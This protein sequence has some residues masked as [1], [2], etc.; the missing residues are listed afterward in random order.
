MSKEL[1]GHRG[2]EIVD[3]DFIISKLRSAE[4]SRFAMPEREHVQGLL[5][6]CR[7]YE[8]KLLD[9]TADE[10]Y[11]A[12]E[13]TLNKLARDIEEGWTPGA[14]K[15]HGTGF[16]FRARDISI[17]DSDGASWGTDL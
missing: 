6:L 11:A 13:V 14:V 4:R 7:A 12:A 5:R 1:E 16:R 15:Q 8:G 2:R 9:A 3:T 17:E 10:V